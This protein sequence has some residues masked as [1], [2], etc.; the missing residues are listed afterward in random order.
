MNTWLREHLDSVVLASV[1]LLCGI[2]ILSIYSATFDMGGLSFFHRQMIFAG[3][4]LV[5]MCII[6][7]TPFRTIQILSYP[8]YGVSIVILGMILV[9]GK[10]VAGSKSWFGVGGFGLQPSEL[11]KVTTILA[12]AAYLSQRTV[13]LRRTK[14]ILVT[15][16]IVL[17]P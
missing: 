17:I 14:D 6:L 11:A 2:S 10:V 16:S 7:L 1:I 3:V 5:L 8:L 13:N 12:L 9:A 4:G 15:F